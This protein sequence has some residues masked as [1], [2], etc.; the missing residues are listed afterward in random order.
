MDGL[1]NEKHFHSWDNDATKYKGASTS[2]LKEKL[3]NFFLEFLRLC[4]VVRELNQG[5]HRGRQELIGKCSVVSAFIVRL[6]QVIWD[7]K[8]VLTILELSSTW[9]QSFEDKIETLK[10]LLCKLSAHVIH[11]TTEQVDLTS[12]IW[13]DGCEIHT[14]EKGSL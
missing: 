9:C 13:R 11:L 2:R 14:K 3:H 10:F 6:F 7:P 1:I 4:P 5:V 8:R 12:W